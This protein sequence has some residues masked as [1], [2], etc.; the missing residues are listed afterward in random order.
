MKEELK[1]LVE[2]GK[3]AK[4]VIS[5]FIGASVIRPLIQL[6]EKAHDGSTGEFKESTITLPSKTGRAIVI[7]VRRGAPDNQGPGGKPAFSVDLE[8]SQQ[9]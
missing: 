3:A 4:N 5:A 8:I 6:L 1:K 9:D 7:R 2:V